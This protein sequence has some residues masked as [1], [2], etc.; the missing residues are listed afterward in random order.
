MTDLL[1]PEK[2]TN[3]AIHQ[4][5]LEQFGGATGIRDEGG[6]DAA[7][8]RPQNLLDYGEKDFDIFD[9]AASVCYSITKNRHPFADGNKRVGAALCHVILLA[10]GFD[11]NVLQDDFR[12]TILDVASGDLTEKSFA[13]WCRSN[14]FKILGAQ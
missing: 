6:I 12:D 9:V 3:I 10:N 4:S 11:L 14:S 1:I 2:R 7:I 8:V 13:E 5:Q